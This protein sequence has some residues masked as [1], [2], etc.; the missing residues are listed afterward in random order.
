MLSE[1]DAKTLKGIRDSFS[2]WA[3]IMDSIKMEIDDIINRNETK[4]TNDERPAKILSK[5]HDPH[6]A[7]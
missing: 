4:E 1:K 2:R 6:R 3:I 7:S 5:R